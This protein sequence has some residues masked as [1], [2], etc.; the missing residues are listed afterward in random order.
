MDLPH[1]SDDDVLALPIRAR[2]LTTLAALRRP[3]TTQELAD[4]VLRHAN[5]TRVQLRRLADAGLIECRPA[6]QA[7]GRPRHEWAVAATA[8]PAGEPPQAH[9]DLSR[10]LA[11]AIDR[12]RHLED[13]EAAGREIGHELAPA[14]HTRRLRE[15]MHDALA[16]MGFAPHDDRHAPDTVHY[17]L[18]NCPYRQTAAE[19]PAV[20]CT[21]HRGITRGLLDKLDPNARLTGFV[22]K[23]PFAAGC[24]IELESASL[25]A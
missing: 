13:V 12:G 23:D 24:V 17:V 8:R 20:V 2:L 4:L 5:S 21:L 1:P 18:A 3:A 16:S 25:G 9:G 6:A 7:R 14:D 15:S 11:R 19:N 10:W 22:A